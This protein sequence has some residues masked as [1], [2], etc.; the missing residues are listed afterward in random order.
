[1]NSPA[2]P[3][4]SR[5][6][7]VGRALSGLVIAFLLF[8]SVIKLVP[9]APVLE[10]MSSLGFASSAE[11]ARTLGV[12]LLACTLLY[13]LPRTA[14]LGAVLVT[15]YLG[16]AIAIQLRAGSPVL[17]HLLFGVYVGALLWAGLLLQNRNVRALVFSL[18]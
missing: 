9:I 14:L 8:D 4:T 18:H 6:V 10:T 5:T 15:G 11:L 16:G 12:L 1:M 3:N 13:A 17:S 7:W 2:S